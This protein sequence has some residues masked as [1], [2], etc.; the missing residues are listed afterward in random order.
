MKKLAKEIVFHKWSNY[1]TAVLISFLLFIILYFVLYGRIQSKIE[2]THIVD[3]VA[4][5][6][7]LAVSIGAVYGSKLISPPRRKRHLIDIFGEETEV[8]ITGTTRFGFYLFHFDIGSQTISVEEDEIIVTTICADRKG[9]L[10]E[11]RLSGVWRVGKHNWQMT[12]FKKLDEN[13]QENEVIFSNMLDRANV[14]LGGR[15]EF[16]SQIHGKDLHKSILNDPI[17]VED[18]NDYG[19]EFPSLSLTV[20]SADQATD[21]FNAQYDRELAKYMSKYPIGYKFTHKE[22]KEASD[23]IFAKLGR[24]K[25][26]IVRG[27]AIVRTDADALM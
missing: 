14:R 2:T 26:L 9:K 5:F 6:G 1:L 17:F 21:N 11:M 16:W 13:R 18:K 24:A 22:L 27:G 4:F 23:L 19:I 20:K 10:I 7:L 8:W 12:N 25:M 3:L 15:K